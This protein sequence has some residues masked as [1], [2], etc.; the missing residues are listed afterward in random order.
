MTNSNPYDDITD[1]HLEMA[2]LLKSL[3]DAEWDSNTLKLK[4]EQLAKQHTEINEEIFRIE[5]S[6]RK[7]IE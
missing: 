4:L 5:E 2:D 1:V 7:K 6:E 3:I